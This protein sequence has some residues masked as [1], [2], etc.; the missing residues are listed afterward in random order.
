[1]SGSDEDSPKGGIVLRKRHPGVKKCA[2]D[3]K[4]NYE[5]YIGPYE[6]DDDEAMRHPK[7][8]GRKRYRYVR[9]DRRERI[10]GD[11]KPEWRRNKYGENIDCPMRCCECFVGGIRIYVVF[12]ITVL[13]FIG[14]A[15][16]LANHARTFPQRRIYPPIGTWVTTVL[17]QG[18][19]GPDDRITKICTMTGRIFADAHPTPG[20]PTP[21]YVI[22]PDA[23]K[24]MKPPKPTPCI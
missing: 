18:P 12:W 22:I 21:D 20:S 17:Y 16:Y 11:G 4:R 6:Y 7:V 8:P 10:M 19:K 14:W 23:R 3:I 2:P 24:K 5:K 13:Y 9:K 1:M 15:G